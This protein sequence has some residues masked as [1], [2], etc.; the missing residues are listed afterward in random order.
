M[1]GEGGKVSE[2]LCSDA[3][4]GESTCEQERILLLASNSANQ[5]D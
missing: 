2:R 1:W 3:L 4:I 5:R